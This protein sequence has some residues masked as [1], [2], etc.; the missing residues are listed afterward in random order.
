MLMLTRRGNQI[1]ESKFGAE[2]RLNGRL[3]LDGNFKGNQLRHFL[4]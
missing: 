3:N 4:L 2:E 1:P